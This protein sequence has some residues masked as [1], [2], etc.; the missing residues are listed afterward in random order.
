MLKSGRGWPSTPLQVRSATLTFVN[1]E[2]GEGLLQGMHAGAKV[3]TCSCRSE[4][5]SCSNGVPPSTEGLS[6][7]MNLPPR[8]DEQG[9]LL[10]LLPRCERGSWY[11]MMAAGRSMPRLAS[12]VCSDTRK[13]ACEKGGGAE[14]HD[15]A[16]SD[17][18]TG[19]AQTN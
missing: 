10:L 15:R 18:M 1:Q 19:P 11:V 4:T 8:C 6:L 5:S 12:G 2:W 13:K 16:C 17:F 3:Q 7:Q 14:Y 9:L